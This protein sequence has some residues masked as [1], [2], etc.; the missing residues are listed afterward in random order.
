MKTLFLLRHASATNDNEADFNRPLSEEGII[1]CQKAATILKEYI[2]DIDLILCSSA[3]RTCQTIQIIL[4]NLKKPNV[5]IDYKDNLYQ[6]SVNQLFQYIRGLDNKYKNILLVNHNP[7]IS[8][9]AIFLTKKN[10]PLYSNIIQGF[11]P[12]NI[13]YYQ[14]NIKYWSDLEPENVELKIFWQ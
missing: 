4:A 6:A 9:L 8:R 11:D 13:A 1:E 10:S 12:T 14:A 5:E 2:N 3:L 7:A